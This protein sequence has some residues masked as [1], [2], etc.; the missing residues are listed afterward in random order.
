MIEGGIAG[1]V[2]LRTALPFDSDGFVAAFSAEADYGNLVEDFNP[3]GSALIS[4][5]WTTDAGDF[6]IMA[7]GAYS[8]VTTASQGVQILR[9]FRNDNIPE[10]GGGTK[11]VPGGVDIREAIYDR[12]R[13]GAAVAAQWRS[14]D[15]RLLATLQYNRSEYENDWEEFSLSGGIGNSQTAQDLVL[16]SPLALPAEGT[17]AYEFDSRG[18]F[19]RGV[20]NDSVNSWAGPNNNPQLSHP[21]GFMTPEGFPNFYCYSWSTAAGTTCPTTRGIGLSADARDAN[22]LNITEDLSLNLRWEATDRLAFNFDLQHV[23]ATVENFDNSA[24]AK[25]ASDVYLD[26]SGGRPQFEFRAPT[27]F[28]FTEGGFADPRNYYHEWVMEHVEQGE[29]EEWAGRIDAE[30]DLTDGWMDSLRVG[31]RRAE[32]SQEINWSTYNWGSVQPLWG[33]QSDEAFFLDGYLPNARSRLRSR[34]WRRVRRRC[35][36]ASEH[37]PHH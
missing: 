34:R 5:R 11:W 6:G 25:T 28:G 9:Y 3:E 29:G 7:S 18:V 13:I 32:R 30:I 17:P 8:E 22:T 15:E 35:L 4:N 24:N 37:G 14:P 16:T 2:N 31:V 10:Y 26:V 21:N 1:T 33:V 36:R 20:L 27:G 12:T 23:D 19:M